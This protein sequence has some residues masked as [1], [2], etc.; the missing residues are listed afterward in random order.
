VL[1]DGLKKLFHR[2]RS[3]RS[4]LS[5]AQ[6]AKILRTSLYARA[7]PAP[8]RERL[9]G[10]IARFMQTKSFE[11]ASGLAVSEAM[12][13]RIA[14]H[15]CIPILN[16]GSDYYGD[17]VSVVIYPGDFRVHNEYMDEAGVVHRE[18]QDL[19][20]RSLSR[21]P[22]VLSWEAI[23][24]EDEAPTARDLVI[25]ECAHKL[26]ILNG[27]ANGFPPL[28][29]GM[30]ADEWSRDF[31]IAYEQLR[32]GLRGGNPGRIDSYAGEAPAEF[33]AVLSEAFFTAPRI[34][35][36]DFPAVYA[37]LA[38]FYR[39]DPVRMLPETPA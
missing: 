5:D 33:F 36:E 24:K 30:N 16:L 17:W 31:R 37:Q 15:A 28:H 18:I 8:E 39:Q 3:G 38:R 19:C 26:D 32:S 10:L 7:L 29:P 21:G 14:L 35:R 6:W 11:G 12:R 27:N 34:V 13:A 22:I 1:P 23:Q 9:R 20:G 25:H 4:P 2:R